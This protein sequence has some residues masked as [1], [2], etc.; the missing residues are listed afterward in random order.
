MQNNIKKDY[1]WNTLGVF[2]QNAISPLLLIVITRI[3]GIYDS[4]IFSFAFSVAIIF[5]V[6][7][8]WGGRTFQVSDIKHEFSHR[9]YIMVRI[10][11]A[12]LMLLGAVIFSVSNGYDVTKSAIIVALVLFKVAE[13]IADSIYGVL[14]VHNRLF[15]A[16]TSLLYK[17][18]G[19]FGAFVLIDALTHSILLGSLAIVIV[20]V[21]VI[22]FY[23]RRIA[24]K[25]EDIKI[26]PAQ[27]GYYTKDA[28]IIIRRTAPFFAVTFLSTFSLNIPR[29]FIDKYDSDQIG[30]FGI[31]A[32]PITLIV[33]LVSFLL[34]PNVVHL[35]RLYGQAKYHSFKKTVHTLM[36]VTFGAGTV[37]LLGTITV[38]VPALGL[39]FGV[40]FADYKTALIIMVAGGVANALVGVFMNILTIMRR[41]KAQFY[42][43][44][45]TNTVL[46]LACVFTLRMHGMIG[47]VYLFAIASTLQL[48]LLLM[49]YNGILRKAIDAEEN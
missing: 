15:D 46:T 16:G 39:V 21:V 3:N 6:L 14:Q 27:A 32:M 28:F 7:G 38:G 43:L 44:L 24:R 4:G 13:S 19:G 34:Q 49:V 12:V 26:R 17:A 36:L 35:S 10:I 5:L 9:S 37:I 29:Y 18:V 25:L 33:L 30:Y 1:F 22:A 47:G 11:L 8:M 20:N 48:V 45:I 2:A 23:D 40:S 41:F 42:I 31:I